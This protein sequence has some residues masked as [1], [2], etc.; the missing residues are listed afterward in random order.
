MRKVLRDKLA[1][2]ASVALLVLAGTLLSFF[3]ANEAYADFKF[4]VP[5]GY[6]VWPS[7]SEYNINF[8]EHFTHDECVDRAPWIEASDTAEGT[9]W[10]S[11]GSCWQMKRVII[12][13]KEVDTP[14]WMQ[15][16]YHCHEHNNAAPEEVSPFNVTLQTTAT[17]ESDGTFISKFDKQ[18]SEGKQDLGVHVKFQKFEPRATSKVKDNGGAVDK[19]ALMITDEVTSATNNYWPNFKGTDFSE[20]FTVKYCARVYGPHPTPQEDFVGSSATVCTTDDRK[21]HENEHD[22][23]GRPSPYIAK[24]ETKS[25]NFKNRGP[26]Y[27]YFQVFIPRDQPDEDTNTLIRNNWYA[28]FN[29]PGEHEMT[30][31]KKN[32]TATSQVNGPYFSDAAAPN[33]I[34]TLTVDA[35]GAWLNYDHDH[36]GD[37]NATND[38]VVARICVAMHGPYQNPKAVNTPIPAGESVVTEKCNEVTKEGDTPFNFGP[39]SNYTPGYYYFTHTVKNLTAHAGDNMFAESFEDKVLDKETIIRKF[40]PYFTSKVQRV[41]IDD[42]SNNGFQIVDTVRSHAGSTLARANNGDDNNIATYWLNSASVR[43]CVRAWGPYQQAQPYGTVQTALPSTNIP[44]PATLA[45]VLCS[46]DNNGYGTAG[47]NF[48]GVNQEREFRFN[49]TNWNP[50][51]YYFTEHMLLSEQAANVQN[52]LIGD[53]HSKFNPERTGDIWDDEATIEKFQIKPVSKT[54][55]PS[56]TTLNT[57]VKGDS[58]QNGVIDGSD[59]AAGT[60]PVLKPSDAYIEDSF[61][62][63]AYDTNKQDDTTGNAKPE[64]WLKDLNGNFITFYVCAT[65]YGPYQQPQGAGT[66]NPNGTSSPRIPLTG[67]GQ[68]T[69][70]TIPNNYW[71]NQDSR[72]QCFWTNDTA[73][74]STATDGLVAKPSPTGGPGVYTVRWDNLAD[75]YFQPGYYYVVWNVDASFTGAADATHNNHDTTVNIGEGNVITQKNGEFLES[76]WW[77]PFGEQTEA[78]YAQFQPIAKSTIPEFTNNNQSDL[79]GSGCTIYYK[80]GKQYC[81]RNNGFYINNGE[82]IAITEPPVCSD[83]ITNECIIKSTSDPSSDNTSRRKKSVANNGDG[84]IVLECDENK[85]NY[86]VNYVDNPEEYPHE[87]LH[88]HNVTDQIWLASVNDKAINH[89]THEVGSDKNDDRYWPKNKDSQW[90]PVKFQVKLYGPFKYPYTRTPSDEN[91]A[92]W[93]GD[94]LVTV[95][96]KNTDGKAVEV[97]QTTYGQ[98]IAQSCVISTSNVGPNW[99]DPAI[100]PFDA[101]FT[102]DIGSCLGGTP[103]NNTIELTPGFYVSV[104]EIVRDGIDNPDATQISTRPHNMFIEDRFTSAWGDRRES[105]LVPIPLYI[106]TRRDNSASDTFIDQVTINDQYWV[107]GFS[108]EYVGE[109]GKKHHWTDIWGQDIPAYGTYSGEEGYVMNGDIPNDYKYS[110]SASD[111][112][113]Y[114]QRDIAGDIH[115]RLYGAYPLENGRPNENDEYCVANKLVKRGTWALPPEDTPLGGRDLPYPAPL[116]LYEKGWYVFQ[117][118]YSGGDRITNM[119]TQC[120][121][122]HEMFRI[123]K[124]QIGLVTTAEAEQKMAPTVITDTVQVTGSFQESDK[125]SIVKLSLYKRAGTT[126]SP[127]ATGADGAPLCVVIFTVDAAGVYSTKDYIDENGHVSADNLG[128][129][130]CYAETGGHYYW[131]EEFLRPGSPPD[132]PPPSDYIQP[133]GDGSPPEDVDITPP[134]PP[135]VT[136]DSDPTT[137]INRPFKDVALVTNIPEGNTKVYKLWFTAYGPFADGR[138]DCVSQLIYSNQSSP[139]DVTKNGRYDSEFITVSSNGIVYW[140]EHLEDDEGNI[141]SQGECGTRRENTYIVGTDVPTPPGPFTPFQVT[142]LYP[143]AGYISQQLG[144]VIAL[145]IMSMLGAWQLTNKNSWLLRKR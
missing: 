37:G 145:G 12:D 86:T 120:G 50:G 36:N 44:A 101:I 2:L 10:A 127:G 118:T 23:Q 80:D 6:V 21:G 53:W 117:Y 110:H 109:D 33:I 4:T 63:K 88:C 22:G 1:I 16:Y 15:V 97:A 136:T 68:A 126:N 34:D 87:K 96:P 83:T 42:I 122:T 65:I 78:F 43:V 82:V 115:V 60:V 139:I 26:G 107:A 27:Y 72:Q 132:N 76:N 14:D 67:I 62:I 79:L 84:G 7:H 85:Y 35:G 41:F 99:N 45:G 38:P 142:P 116:T 51:Y 89:T 28:K 94:N 70:P 59:Q 56:A 73:K 104:V 5:K 112:G 103:S 106:I 131:I 100:M 95:V 102:Q 46:G 91:K 3:S 130:R 125:G 57:D 105:I 81:Y 121:D 138:V 32:I 113:D 48:A 9:A 8:A 133:P 124:D 140:V 93:A 19:D 13:G 143:D 30:V 39:G 29:P 54:V 18:T 114:Y 98:P 71:G 11:T 49:T 135:E 128:S 129:G 66:S 40:Q 137:S 123:I 111:V 119:K 74:P 90:E 64:Y 61:D 20:K 134:T 25:F 69:P 24:N 75:K 108:G 47:G 144:K 58:N 77:S 92:G 55:S 141:V 17:D 31:I 52:L